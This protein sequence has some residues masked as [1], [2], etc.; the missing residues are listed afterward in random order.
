M[1][2]AAETTAARL[3]RVPQTIRHIYLIGIGGSAMTALA[4]ML[5][6]RGWR[7]TGSDQ[8]IYEPAASLLKQLAITVYEGYAAVHLTPPPDVVVVGNV[9]TSANPEAMALRASGIPYL[10]M[11]EALRHFFLQDRRVLMVAGT[12]GKTTSTALMAQVL[13]AAG[14]DPSMLV[15]GLARNFNANY[16]LGDGPDFVIEGDEYDTAF[17]DKGPKFLHYGARGA[18][19]T[20]VEFDHADIYRD[21][22]QVKAAFAAL[23]ARMASGSVLAVCADFPHALAATAATGAKRLTFGLSAGSYRAAAIRLGADGA[24]FQITRDGVVVA[25]ELYLPVGGRMNV[26]NALGVWVLLKEF[27]LS[28]RDLMDGLAS[29]A[30]VARRQEVIGEA[31]GVTIIDDFGHHPTAITATLAALA[32]R[33]RGRRILAAFEPRSNTARRAVF[34]REFAAAFDGAAAVFLAPVYFKDNDPLPVAERLD[35]ATLAAAIRRRGPEAAACASV[36]EIIA[37]IVAAARLGDVVV[38][39]SNGPFENLPQRLRT[40]LAGD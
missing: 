29:F 2:L 38:C 31:G 21:L 34:Q 24:R 28:D 22:D 39:F 18:I 13:A 10:S 9:V 15:G 36:D 11:P 16:R 14:R 12:H 30:G 8:Q 27:G 32:E 4:A 17:F 3:A 20:A 40:A 5:T 25:R 33:F 19:I 1:E 26:A 35:V 6:R 23:A 37:R 7:V